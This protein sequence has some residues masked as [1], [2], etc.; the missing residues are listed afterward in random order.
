[1]SE[2][3]AAP[4]GLPEQVAA[5]NVA[6]EMTPLKTSVTPPSKSST[7]VPPFVTVTTPRMII[8]RREFLDLKQDVAEIRS[9]IVETKQNVQSISNTLVE[10]AK[11]NGEKLDA[12]LTE[13]KLLSEGLKDRYDLNMKP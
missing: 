4:N 8:P 13:M 3:V 6:K 5:Q 10:H 2:E 1:M 12:I 7:P 11:A 9:E